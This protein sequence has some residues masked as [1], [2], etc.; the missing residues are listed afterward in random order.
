MINTILRLDPVESPRG[1]SKVA[2][3]QHLS[4]MKMQWLVQRVHE[5]FAFSTDWVE[6]ADAGGRLE[7]RRE[8]RAKK[9]ME[10]IIL[11]SF[12]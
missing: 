1:I 2:V 10:T 4:Y 8:P 11:L 3:K 6:M 12:T 9:E 5:C 7:G